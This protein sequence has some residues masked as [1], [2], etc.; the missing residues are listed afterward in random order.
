MAGELA[1]NRAT[2]DD[3]L[4]RA[5]QAA[6][7]GEREISRSLLLA[8]VQE[9]ETNELAWLWLSGV[10][11]TAEDRRICL[12]NVL[13]LNP[14]NAAA[15]KGLA[16]LGPADQRGAPVDDKAGSHDQV[17]YTVRREHAPISPAA[18]VLYPERQVKEWQW[19]ETELAQQAPNPGFQAV[20]TYDDVW[21]GNQELCGYC[22]QPVTVDWSHCPRCRQRLFGWRFRYPEASAHF[23]VYLVLLVGLIQLLLAQA[24]V[25][26]IISGPIYSLVVHSV[27]ALLFFGLIIAIYLR[28]FFA[29][30]FSVALLVAMAFVQAVN[31]FTAGAV[32]SLIVGAAPGAV[33]FTEVSRQLSQI[34]G[35]SLIDLLQPFQLV[36]V[37][38]AA[39]QGVFKAGPDF[40]RVQV[41]YIARVETGLR[42]AHEFYAAGKAYGGEQMWA[43]AVL[44]FQRAAA[45]EPR[46][47][48]YQIAVA[49]AYAILGFYERALDLLASAEQM[50]PDAAVKTELGQLRQDAERQ[51]AQRTIQNG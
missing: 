19:Q 23:Y 14:A 39:F 33:P 41:R 27:L 34:A 36:T 35:V 13:A 22:A 48:A 10:V 9:D 8:I 44:Y 32:S 28:S 51:M 26:V 15:Q 45:L 6:R 20:S 16:R 30:G 25:D 4:R 47:I 38:F 17:A 37:I 12:E 2:I 43:T 40:E 21:S 49:R 11:A 42:E 3:R 18:A 5:I 50:A 46:R 31:L 1:E 24:L 7:S 29:Y